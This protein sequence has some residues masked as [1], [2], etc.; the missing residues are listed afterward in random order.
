MNELN[1][2]PGK[3][4]AEEL[5]MMK[6]N[7]A[8]N[9]DLDT[10]VSSQ[11]LE[12]N[13]LFAGDFDSFKAESKA[14]LDE[15]QKNPSVL[16][17]D[18]V[19]QT[20]VLNPKS[21]NKPASISLL[22]TS[23]ESYTESRV[24]SELLDSL[25]DID[26][27]ID[28]YDENA[29]WSV[30]PSPK[31]TTI[32]DLEDNISDYPKVISSFVQLGSS[33]SPEI[34]Y[35]SIGI[36]SKTG[37][38]GVVVDYVGGG[39]YDEF[40]YI[41]GKELINPDDSTEDEFFEEFA[42]IHGTDALRDLNAKGKHTITWDAEGLYP[43]TNIDLKSFDDRVS[44]SNY[45]DTPSPAN[46]TFTP[47]IQASILTSTLLNPTN[48]ELPVILSDN[49]DALKLLVE[50]VYFDYISSPDFNFQ[51]FI[52]EVIDSAFVYGSNQFLEMQSFI[53]SH[54]ASIGIS[55]DNEYNYQRFYGVTD[56]SEL[57]LLGLFRSQEDS[58]SNHAREESVSLVLNQ[59]EADGFVSSCEMH[60]SNTTDARIDAE[61]GQLYPSHEVS[62]D[63]NVID[64]SVQ[65]LIQSA[66][67]YYDSVGSANHYDA[68]Q[69]SKK[70]QKVKS[71]GR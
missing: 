40:H 4:T 12:I 13:S 57:V 55:D 51:S 47:E 1:T 14:F 16:D 71:K 49:D 44:I 67:N 35:A 23:K 38:D 33:S 9:D 65:Q 7:Q 54:R 28:N 43:I 48:L 52:S 10:S 60:I 50:Y 26:T 46:T 68:P 59:S 20:A 61:D 18:F 27:A 6:P 30:Y 24:Q 5:A 3:L 53:K 31:P 34:R 56:E 45:P 19:F 66:N 15:I 32:H 64:L 21:G 11:V 69:Q 2:Q 8:L 41:N 37:F 63:N 17:D 58:A 39:G 42:R 29:T 70:S 25:A 36:N 62:D 22:F